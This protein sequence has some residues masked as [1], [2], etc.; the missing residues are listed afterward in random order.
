MQSIKFEDGSRKAEQV[1]SGSFG[2]LEMW[3]DRKQLTIATEVKEL[4][5][6]EVIILLDKFSV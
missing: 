1:I 4:T 5:L 6:A 3:S 2:Y